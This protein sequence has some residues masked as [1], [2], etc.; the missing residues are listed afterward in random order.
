MLAGEQPFRGEQ[1]MQIAY[2]HAN[3]SVPTP[4]TKNPNVPAELDELVLWATARDPNE[5]PRDARIL[6]EQVMETQSQLQTALPT[7]A[8]AIIQR[9]TVM[10]A[11]A[12]FGT[13]DQTQVIRAP[14]P[15]G[16]V[17]PVSEATEALTKRANKR[18]S[19]AWWWI[20]LFILL[21]GAAGGT[22]WYFGAGPGSTVQIPTS[23]VIGAA[24]D[25]AT[26]AIEDVG[27]SVSGT[28]TPVYSVDVPA[29]S[30]ASTDPAA[31]EAVARDTVVTLEISQGPKP[32]AVPEFVGLSEQAAKDLAT[33]TG[34]PPTDSEQQF[35]ADVAAGTV[36]A[37]FGVGTD[38][39]RI[40]LETGTQY[41]DQKPVT[42]LVSAGALPDVAGLPVNDAIALLGTKNVTA[43]PLPE[44]QFNNDIASGS[45]ISL[46]TANADAPIAPGDSVDLVVSKGPDLVVIPDVVGETI[47]DARQMLVDAGFT[48]KLDTNVPTAFQN[49]AEVQSIK[50][51]AAEAL[52]GSEITIVSRYKI[53]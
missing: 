17:K 37:A 10:P 52:R 7:G 38:G 18:H 27:L 19:R 39:A 40:Q 13:G 28:Q 35:S 49:S 48:V 29:G 12:T 25:A 14:Q 36:L 26:A 47:P 50:P 11:A 44:L 15:S 30:V 42:F 51:D 3:D 6:L 41:F 16:P 31:G 22:G 34:F 4:S 2:Q 9:T 5:R 1:P 24:P 43:T 45:V 8:T 46:Q 20:V 53:G 33:S 32:V 23:G 21:A